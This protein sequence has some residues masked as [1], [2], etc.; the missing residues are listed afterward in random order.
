MKLVLAEKPSVAKDIAVVLGATQKKDGYIEGNGY[1]ITWCIGHLVQLANPE[2]YNEILKKWSLD[3]LPILPE[4]F[5]KETASSTKKQFEI[6]QELI[7]KNHEIICATD[8]GREGQLIFEYVFRLNKDWK[9]KKVYR[10]WISSMTDE[11]IQEGFQ[12]LKDNSS[13]ENLY[14]AARCRSEADWLV[15]INSTRLFSVLYNNKL[16]IGRVQTPTLSLIVER[17]KA[18]ETF[19][20]T[21]YFTIDGLF[22]GVM[23]H[24]SREKENRLKTNLEAQN[25]KAEL[26]GK[27][28]VVSRLDTARKTEDRP[29]LFDLT[30]LQREANKRYGY[31][32]QETLNIAQSLYETHKLTTYPR[33]D[34]R[35]LTEDIKSLL[36]QLLEDLKTGYTKI[37]AAVD[38]ILQE[39]LH[40]DQRV[41]NN[42]K[43]SDHHAIIPTNRIKNYDLKKLNEKEHNIYHLIAARLI[44]TLYKKVDYDETN[45]EISMPNGDLF[46]AK[47][48]VIVEEGWRKIEKLLG[49]GQKNDSEEDTKE[50]NQILDG[51][52][53]QQELPIEEIKINEK[54]TTPPKPFTE[55]SLLTAMEKVSKEVEAE[56]LKRALKE[57]GLGTPAT[58]A[59]IIEKLISSE[60]VIRQKKTLVPTD[61]GKALITLLPEKIKSAELTGE[62]EMQLEQIAEGS[63]RPEAFMKNIKNFVQEL[64]EENQAIDKNAA[65]NLQQPSKEIIGKCPKCGGNVYENQKSFYCENYRNNPPCKFSLWKNNRF[66]EYKGKQIT[67]TVA[68]EL[69]K[70]GKVKMKKLKAKS[71]KEYDAVITMDASGEQVNFNMLFEK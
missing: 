63:I 41:I 7:N 8:A 27:T 6:V 23:T 30:E 21:P 47:G 18:I 14:Q 71:G 69:L 22:K 15:G 35:Y 2:K 9:N 67:K 62:W 51:F 64:V 56:N 55:A 1:Q 19:Q 32:A 50:E 10:L 13:Y 44:I 53:L 48:R 34:S 65:Q 17:Q 12:N 25:V 54:R 24:W 11:A 3:T 28:G 68:K 43:V 26:E 52:V 61:K 39:G 66:F 5:K 38:L 4:T 16:T 36:P 31:T 58:R 60:Y 46:A 42:S 57:K 45:L 70:N 29:Q 37:T 49:L 59:S 20:S 40:T 33:T